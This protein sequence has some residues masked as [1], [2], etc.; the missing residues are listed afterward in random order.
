MK[1][2]LKKL[3]GSDLRSIGLSN[4]VAEEVLGN[5]A[6]FDALFNGM[7]ADNPV[8]RMRSADAIEKI[9]AKRPELLQPYKR[10]LIQEVAKINQ[11]EIRWHMAQMFPRLSLTGNERRIVMGILLDYLKDNSSIVRTFSMQA[12]TDLAKSDESL[13]PQVAGVI[14]ELTRT[15]SPAMKSRGKKLMEKM[16]K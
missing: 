10:K 15:G 12:L 1:N 4:E 11:Q 2:I 6:L 8:L 16:K 13:Q 3:Q 7:L 9:S 14:E 5:P